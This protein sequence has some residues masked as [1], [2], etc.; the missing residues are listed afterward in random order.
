MGDKRTN[1][2][3]LLSICKKANV[4]ISAL[5]VSEERT[6][7]ILLRAIAIAL[8]SVLNGSGSSGNAG[9]ISA[10]IALQA[11][12]ETDISVNGVLVGIILGGNTKIEVG[13]N[14][15]YGTFEGSTGEVLEVGLLQLDSIKVKATEA[16]NIKLL[17]LK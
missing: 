4:D 12:V 7:Y 16:V 11:G 1:L 2:E 6:E 8:E 10:P 13:Q 3:I 9:N 15:F 14:G 5:K 17:I